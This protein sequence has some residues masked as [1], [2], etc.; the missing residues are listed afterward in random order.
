M[1]TTP[2]WSLSASL[3]LTILPANAHAQNL[4]RRR[5]PSISPNVL[6]TAQNNFLASSS[7]TLTA[8]AAPPP[9]TTLS[10]PSRS[11]TRGT[12]GPSRWC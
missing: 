1:S 12:G 11:P 7:W 2:G 8:S 5:L 6:C 3:R 9:Q 4:S 10:D